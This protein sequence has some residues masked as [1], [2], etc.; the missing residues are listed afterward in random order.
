MDTDHEER[1]VL[2]SL[3]DYFPGQQVEIMSRTDDGRKWIVA[4]HS[5]RDAGTFYLFDRDRNSMARLFTMHSDIPAEALSPVQPISYTS[6][7]NL[8]IHGYLTPGIG[9]D[10]NE[11]PMVVMVHGGPRAR[12]H[13]IYNPEVQAFATRGISVLQVNYRGSTGYGEAFMDAGN[14]EW[15]N[16]VQ[17]DIINGVKWA[18]AEGHADPGRVCIMG[19]SYGA[20]SAVMSASIEPDMFRCVVANAGLYDLEL[21]YKRG[22]IKDLFFGE[23]F[24]EEMI[25]TDKGQL[26]AFSPVDQVHRVKAPVLVAHGKKDRRTPFVHAKRLVS[27]MKKAGVPHETL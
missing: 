14:G 5:D 24:I 10:T 13:W 25:G 2:K 16:K 18:I 19:A 1:D 12:D 9:T 3:L 15:G 23:D 11:R 17:Q 26:A 27:A 8:T 20:Y 4:T 6:V 21:M 22:D 7:D